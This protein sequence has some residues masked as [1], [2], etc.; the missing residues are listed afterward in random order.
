MEIFADGD[1]AKGLANYETEI[2]RLSFELDKSRNS[3]AREYTKLQLKFNE[4]K[5][6]LIFLKA[7]LSD[8][9][10]LEKQIDKTL[11]GFLEHN[12]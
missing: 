2:N 7:E 5:E 8:K 3:H 1:V 11:A 4:A 10:S 9:P 6:C 12:S